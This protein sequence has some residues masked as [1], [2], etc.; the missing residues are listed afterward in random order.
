[1]LFFELVC[2]ILVATALITEPPSDGLHEGRLYP[3]NKTIFS[4]EMW[5]NVVIQVILQITILGTILFKG[6]FIFNSGPE[7][8]GVQASIGV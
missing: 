7:L 4:P 1:M 2:D 3:R 6:K 8:F 5:K